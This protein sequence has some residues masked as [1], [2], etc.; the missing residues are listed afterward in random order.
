MYTD[1][2]KSFFD[3]I[4]NYRKIFEKVITESLNYK[5]KL[6]KDVAQL[7]K[8]EVS[9]VKNGKKSTTKIFLF[10]YHNKT[11]QK[12]RWFE[13]MNETILNHIKKYDIENIFGTDTIIKKLFLNEIKIDNEYHYVVPYLVAIFHPT[14]NLVRFEHDDIY[15]YAM[16]KLDI[17]D[18]F[19]FYDFMCDMDSFKD[20]VHAKKYLRTNTLVKLKDNK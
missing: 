12:F 19:V 3:I 17:E 16:I 2:D 8:T 10:G 7:K 1:L 20:M 13:S 14:F 4:L 9:I 6:T 18:D 11:E 15:I 5:I